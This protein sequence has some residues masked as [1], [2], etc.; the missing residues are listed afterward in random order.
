MRLTSLLLLA[1]MAASTPAAA[2]LHP[3]VPDGDFDDWTGVTALGTDA[4]GDGS[5][6][7]LRN[8]WMANDQDW[9]F[10]RFEVTAEIQPDEGQDLVLYLDTDLDAQTGDSIQDIGADLVWELGQRQGRF[11]SPSP[12]FIDHPDIGLRVSPTVSSTQF[13]VALDRHA[14]PAQGKVLFPSGSLRLVIEDRDG[15]DT[16]PSVGSY[17]YTFAAG[18]IARQ[19]RPTDRAGADHLRLVSWNVQSDGLFEGGGAEAA[20]RRLAEAMDPDVFLIQE[21]WNHDA[22]DVAA[23]IESLLPS[24]AGESWNAVMRDAGNVICTRLPILDSWEIFPG[25]RLTGALLDASATLGGPVLVVANHWRC[26]TAD[27][28][29]QDEADALVGFLRDARTPGGSIDL[30][31]DT[32]IL[33]GGDFN[34][35]GWRDQLTTL[36]TGDIQD[37]GSFGP[38]SPPDWDGSDLDVVPA[39]HVDARES[40]SWRNDFSSFYPGL[41]DWVFYTG[42]AVSLGNHFVLET[43]SMMSS[44]LVDLGLQADDTFDASDHAPRVADFHV[45][46]ETAVGPTPRAGALALRVYPNPSN[47]RARVAFELERP[48]DLTLRIYDAAGRRLRELHRGPMESGSHELVW[49]G[50]D[51]GGRPVASGVYFLRLRGDFEQATRSIALV[52]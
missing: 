9:L 46:Q 1:A 40:Y 39:R 38:D 4:V 22:N 52:R 28:E 49:D 5:P 11:Y 16:A 37:E 30:A 13:E 8:V 41:L 33:V 34:L 51:D 31:A 20:Q 27:T 10:L 50:T 12:N 19:V 36:V 43:R 42:S 21:V 15:G 23:Q 26:C 14:L 6:V 44:T 24:G 25:H 7:D 47:P 32:P 48:Q 29:R 17:T 2:A 45:P 18:T 35:V 3:I